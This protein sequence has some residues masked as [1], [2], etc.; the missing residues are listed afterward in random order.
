MRTASLMFAAWTVQ[1]LAAAS[2]ALCCSLVL[3]AEKGCH[4][5][6]SCGMT[7]FLRNSLF[8]LQARY[9]AE[10]QDPGLWA[11]VLSED[12]TYRRQHIDQ[13]RCR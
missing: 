2:W 10:R 7:G 6:A 8:K 5:D 11:K 1:L 9:V 13:V 3:A 12:N 4:A